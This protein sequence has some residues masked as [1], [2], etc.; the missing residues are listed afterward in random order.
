MP[1]NSAK[2]STILISV[3]KFGN[4][5]QVTDVSLWGSYWEDMMLEAK[6]ATTEMLRRMKACCTYGLLHLD[7]SEF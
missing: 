5:M 1:L 7:F 2:V 4:G 3:T 6:D